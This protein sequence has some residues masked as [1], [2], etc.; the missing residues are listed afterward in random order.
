MQTKEGETAL[1]PNPFEVSRK[2]PQ[3]RHFINRATKRL[4]QDGYNDEHENRRVELGV[5]RGEL[6]WF[7][8]LLEPGA[9]KIWVGLA[10]V[11]EKLT[12]DFC[13]IDDEEATMGGTAG[14]HLPR[15][16]EDL[17]EATLP[18]YDPHFSYRNSVHDWVEQTRWVNEGTIVEPGYMLKCYE[19][20]LK[21]QFRIE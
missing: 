17:D 13:R 3:M 14:L 12:F 18:I 16:S 15:V 2:I 9:F 4:D 8:L 11:G 10:F 5:D 20:A 1:L 19:R 7:S 21:K 6:S